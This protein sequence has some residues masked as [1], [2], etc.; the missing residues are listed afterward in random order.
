MNEREGGG[1][2]RERIRDRDRDRDTDTDTDRDRCL[3]SSR[4]VVARR[5]L[6]VESDAGGARVRG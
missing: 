6:C 4:L 5:W 1:G 2:E 3:L